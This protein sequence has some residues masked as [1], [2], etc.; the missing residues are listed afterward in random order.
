PWTKGGWD[1]SETFEHTSVLR[2]LVARFGVKEP[3]ISAWRRSICGVLTSAFD[4]SARPGPRSVG[5]PV[6]Q[7]IAAARPPYPAPA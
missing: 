5:F 1:C 2:F 3:N 7:H 6:P 4:F